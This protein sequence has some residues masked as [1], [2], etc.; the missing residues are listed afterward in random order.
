MWISQPPSFLQRGSTPLISACFTLVHNLCNG[1]SGQVQPSVSSLSVHL[2]SPQMSQYFM[3][4]TSNDQLSLMFPDQLYLNHFS[5]SSLI[6][7]LIILVLFGGTALRHVSIYM[8]D[9]YSEVLHA[10]SNVL[11]ESQNHVGWKRPFRSSNHPPNT[12]RPALNHI[13]KHNS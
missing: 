10:D 13:S 4:P 8:V 7:L 3:G 12:A 5:F 11:P 9:F 1:F 2:I 6:Y